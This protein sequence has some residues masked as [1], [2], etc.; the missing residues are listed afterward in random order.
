MPKYYTEKMIN[1][2]TEKERT[3]LYNERTGKTVARM[4]NKAKAVSA[5][6]ETNPTKEV[7]SPVE[8]IEQQVDAVAKGPVKLSH[9]DNGKD[10]DKPKDLVDLKADSENKKQSPKKNIAVTL[11]ALLK[12]AENG[13]TAERASYL[14]GGKIITMKLAISHIRTGRVDGKKHAI[15]LNRKTGIYTYESN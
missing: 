10:A 5:I 13:I 1:E 4:R 7:L 2:L 6:L 9:K 8:E 12:K 11:L 15:N 14:I 3:A